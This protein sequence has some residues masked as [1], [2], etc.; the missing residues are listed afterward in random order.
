MDATSRGGDALGADDKDEMVSRDSEWEKPKPKK[1]SI[2]TYKVNGT[3][4]NIFDLLRSSDRLQCLCPAGASSENDWH[5]R[6]EKSKKSRLKKDAD[7]F[8]DATYNKAKWLF[9]EWVKERTKKSSED[10]RNRRNEALIVLDTD[11]VTDD[12]PTRFKESLRLQDE[13]ICETFARAPKTAPNSSVR[14]TAPLPS[15]VNEV[16]REKATQTLTFQAATCM[17][18]EN[19]IRMQHQLPDISASNPL[20]GGVLYDAEKFREARIF[21]V[22][23][24]V[25][26][27]FKLPVPFSH[28]FMDWVISEDIPRAK[29]VR[30]VKTLQAELEIFGEIECDFANMPQVWK[31][32]M[33]LDTATLDKV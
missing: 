3:W 17:P 7:E 25:D 23:S 2:P 15:V 9:Q 21:G 8:Y 10:E 14:Q 20:P 24:D 11:I 31:T 12:L 26:K 27:S 13:I 22:S 1:G 18:S 33:K 32:M 5:F 6:V 16:E 28:L 4:V 30:F 29:A 19:G